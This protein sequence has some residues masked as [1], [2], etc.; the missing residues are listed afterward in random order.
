MSFVLKSQSCVDGSEVVVS[1]ITF[2]VSVEGGVTSLV[3]SFGSRF[4]LVADRSSDASTRSLISE[5]G[6]E[7]VTQFGKPFRVLI[8]GDELF[9]TT[10]E[11]V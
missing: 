7:Q 11:G 9:E 8:L 5:E 10:Y 6:V 1:G 4:D 3:N 2:V